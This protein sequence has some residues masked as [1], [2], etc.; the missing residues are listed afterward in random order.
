MDA[1]RLFSALVRQYLFV[2]CFRAFAE[3]AASEHATRVETMQAAKRS[4][5]E[6]LEAVRAEFRR[7]RQEAFTAELLDIVFGYEALSADRASGRRAG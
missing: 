7:R 6:K 4:I 5:D 3:S 1:D 2:A